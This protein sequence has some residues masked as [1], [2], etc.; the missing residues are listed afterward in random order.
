MRR[1][2]GRGWH[3]P[4]APARAG[5]M[6]G[7]TRTSRAQ[8]GLGVRGRKEAPPSEVYV[9]V[10]LGQN[11]QAAVLDPGGGRV[12]LGR[13]LGGQPHPRV[14]G[15]ARVFQPGQH[16]RAVSGTARGGRP[17]RRF[18]PSLGARWAGLRPN[19]G[20][21]TWCGGGGHRNR[22]L[23]EN[24]RRRVQPRS[25]PARFALMDVKLRPATR[26][27]R[28][29]RPFDVRDVR[30]EAA[31]MKAWCPERATLD[32]RPEKAFFRPTAGA[33]PGRPSPAGRG[34][35]RDGRAHGY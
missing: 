6:R 22:F 12:E 3:A 5:R 27:I 32:C 30:S 24:R 33:A 23:Y 28:P 1:L 4:I 21:A 16:R 26:S 14:H 31:V 2:G 7:T 35:Q 13:I 25:T 29:V 10:D 9:D 8:L 19:L 18:G 11:P 17:G 20:R 34:A 15:S